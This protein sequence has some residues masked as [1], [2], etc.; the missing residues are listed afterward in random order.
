MPNLPKGKSSKRLR[1][2]ADVDIAKV[3]EDPTSI[4]FAVVRYSQPEALAALALYCRQQSDGDI[5]ADQERSLEHDRDGVLS[6]MERLKQSGRSSNTNLEAIFAEKADDVA[7]PEFE[8]APYEILPSAPSATDKDGDETVTVRRLSEE[9][10]VDC[11][12][13]AALLDLSEFVS[14]S[15]IASVPAEEAESSAVD[16][17][18]YVSADTASTAGGSGLTFS[19]AEEPTISDDREIL[20]GGEE[21]ESVEERWNETVEESESLLDFEP[22]D[23]SEHEV[24]PLAEIGIGIETEPQLEILASASAQST[25]SVDDLQQVASDPNGN[26][27]KLE[28]EGDTPKES[29]QVNAVPVRKSPMRIEPKPRRA[30]AEITGDAIEAIPGAHNKELQDE[31]K[32]VY[33]K[34]IQRGSVFDAKH[35][36]AFSSESEKKVRSSYL[37]LKAITFEEA[38]TQQEE[39]D[40]SILRSQSQNMITLELPTSPTEKAQAVWAVVDKLHTTPVIITA[41]IICLAFLGF[42]IGGLCQGEGLLQEG[43]KLFEAKKYNEAIKVLSNS[44]NMNPMRAHT[45][46]IRGRAYNKVGEQSKAIDDFTRSLSINPNNVDALDHR[47]SGYMKAGKFDKALT[48]YRRIFELQPNDQTAYR[49]NNAAF[50]ACRGGKFDEA[51]DLYDKALKISPADPNALI[52][53]AQCEVG[54]KHYGKAIVLCEEIIEKDPNPDEA[55]V[56]RGWCYMLLKRYDLALSDFNRA[57]ASSPKNAKAL[58]NRGLLS[59]NRGDLKQALKDYNAAIAVDPGY[60]EARV[61]RGWATINTNPH[62]ALSDFRHAVN[63]TQFGK[64]VEI[65]TARAD[66]ESQLGKKLDAANSYRKTISLASS[67]EPKY[68]PSLYVK[69]ASVLNDLKQY[70]DAIN[71]SNEALSIDAKNPLALTNRGRANDGLGN[72]ISA[73]ADY[74]AALSFAPNNTEALWYR[75]QHYKNQ[76]NYHSAQKD[77]EDFLR[78]RPDDKTVK[79]L[80]VAVKSRTTHAGPEVDRRE[81]AAMKKYA[82]VPFDQLVSSGLKEL[83]SGRTEVAAQMLRE[84]VRKNPS[85]VTARR[86]LCHAYVREDPK[87]AVAQFDIL[88]SA[89]TLPADDERSYRHALSLAATGTLVESSSI[90][91]ALNKVADEPNNGPACYKLATIYAAAGMLSKAAEYCQAGLEGAKNPAETKR[92]QEL[93]QRLNKQNVEGEQKVDIEG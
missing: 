91:K 34:A 55:I 12:V 31:F 18:E 4:F 46:F 43:E 10:R 92:F 5:V 16:I 53:K 84:A 86:Y 68:L 49:Y 48:D 82:A 79:E 33:E 38:L 83:N 2:F 57:I 69:S 87:A 23:Q 81:L 50:A 56:T 67:G 65:W 15:E 42:F 63:S 72:H 78:Q 85:D 59:F 74:S 52:G 35:R 11:S 40:P 7:A 80:L 21:L 25:S 90:D 14:E 73:L 41:S 93:Y 1:K 24:V 58:F 6:A 89:I 39:K 76:R 47:A 27:T 75:A 62:I 20:S 8:T 36:D 9:T 19:E 30:I 3:A 60:V 51:M 28:S 71:A 32:G 44:I 29:S 64:N 61:A 45:L 54:L 26:S 70:N 22:F 37:G 17:S 88:R 13:D 66:L 77:L